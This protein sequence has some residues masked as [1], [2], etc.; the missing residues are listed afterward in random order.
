MRTADESEDEDRNGRITGKNYTKFQRYRSA[1]QRSN[2]ESGENDG[3]YW[4]DWGQSK[5]GNYD[6]RV[7]E[8]D[9][10]ERPPN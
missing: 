7:W 9:Y 2:M 1:V 3:R 5:E 10:W 8:P 6:V 4:L